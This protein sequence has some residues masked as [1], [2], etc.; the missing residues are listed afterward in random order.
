MT[1]KTELQREILLTW[2]ENPDATNAEI[3]EACDCSASYVSQVTSRFDDYDAFQAAL[4]RGDR[5]MASLF[6]D[7]AVGSGGQLTTGGAG[8]GSL[9][10]DGGTQEGVD[11]AAAWDELPNNP[12]GHLLRVLILAV[13]VYVVYEVL[14]TLV[15]L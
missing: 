13:T 10:A 2:R 4:D 6:G 3:A 11:L 8:G 15:A 9:T 5:E 1:E 7:E 12:V 14:T